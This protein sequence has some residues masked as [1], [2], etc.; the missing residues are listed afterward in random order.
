LCLLEKAKL[1]ELVDKA[2]FTR[3]EPIYLFWLW[4]IKEDRGTLLDKDGTLFSRDVRRYED[5]KWNG[6]IGIQL[7][8][9]LLRPS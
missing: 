3:A 8:E 5:D 4:E 6:E 1:G 7:S 2:F 9:S